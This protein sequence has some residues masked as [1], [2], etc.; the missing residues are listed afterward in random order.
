[1]DKSSA[2]LDGNGNLNLGPRVIPPPKSISAQA[3]KFLATPNP[4]PVSEDPPAHE[5][6]AWRKRIS[7]FNAALEP[8]ADQM[9]KAAP[10][11]VE[12]KTIGGVTVYAG[13]PNS[14]PERNRG[15]ARIDLHGGGMV[16]L[17]GKFAMAGAAMGA[18]RTGCVV[19]SVDYRVPPDHP[20]PAAVND[21]VAVYRELL[22]SYQPGHLVISG[23]SGGGNLAAAAALKIRDEGMPLPAGLV[24]L[25]PEVDLTETGDSFE[26][27]RHIDVV[28]KG[29]LPEMIKLY[30][31]GHDLKDPYLSPLF[32]DFTKGYPP[33]FIQTGTR[34]IFLSNSVR[35]HRA[36]LR[37]GIEVELHVWEAMPHGGFGGITPEDVEVQAEIK[38]FIEK[39]WSAA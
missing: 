8:M 22:K 32:G 4:M 17:A 15:R 16:L 18:A 34:D 36:L 14:M 26:T 20:Y 28:L 39:H 33:T 3:Q 11:T 19:Y 2:T 37:A 29:G 24:L 31:D 30:A 6:E 25:T 7:R 5:K 21:T 10:A 13:T 38:R 9:L 23:S 12:T 1:M 35:M 27:N